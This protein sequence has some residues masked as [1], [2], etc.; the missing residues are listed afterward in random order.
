MKNLFIKFF[1]GQPCISTAGR[2]LEL[3]D[4]YKFHVCAHI[5]KT[6]RLQSNPTVRNSIGI[7][8]PSHTHDTRNRKRIVPFPRT[9][10]I[11][12]S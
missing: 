7:L 2:L 5:C 12:K 11:K 3:A 8:Y 4:T 1:T 6:I 9:D 10:A